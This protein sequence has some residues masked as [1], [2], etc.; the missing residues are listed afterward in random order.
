VKPLLLVVAVSVTVSGC[1]SNTRVQ[2]TSDVPAEDYSRQI[3]LTLP[4]DTVSAVFLA[5]QPSR[6][7]IRRRSYGPP[8]AI[9]QTLNALAAEHGIERLEG[10]PIRSLGVY[11]EVFYVP[12]DRAVERV[13]D[14]LMSDA[15]IDLVQRMNVFETLATRYDDPYA[16]LQ[17]SMPQLGLEQAHELATGKGVTVAVIDSAVDASHPDLRGH[18]RVEH[19]LVAD[20]RALRDGEVHGTAVAGIIAST[21]GN[22]EGIVGIAPDV[23]IAALRACWPTSPGSSAAQCSSFSLARALEVAL[24]LAPHVI[25]LSLA[26]PADPLLSALLDETVRR[27]IIVVTAEPER[28]GGHVFPASHPGAIV[29]APAPAPAGLAGPNRLPAPA[30]EILTTVPRAGYAFMSGSSLAAASVSGVIALLLERTP[31]MSAA[32]AVT[33]L[34]QTIDSSQDGG[35]INACGA[36]ARL[37]RISACSPRE[38]LVGVDY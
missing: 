22:S 9:D 1:A 4:A 12:D 36:L 27:G 29:A 34:M 31:T 33:L 30:S 37:T 7:Y 32:D 16:D 3:L 5:G 18:V 25:N 13:I 24:E 26:G 10:W 19:D 15:R 23:D 2:S 38:E 35:S 8:P 17:R 20:G 28:G 11:C 21:A 14:A 6:A